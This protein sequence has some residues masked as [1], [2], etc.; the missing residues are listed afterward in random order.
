MIKTIEIEN[1]Q[2]IAKAKIDLDPGINIIIGESDQG[3]SAV[4]KALNWL[5]FNRPQGDAFVR[6][7]GPDKKAPRCSV[8]IDLGE[9]T[10]IKRYRTEGVNAYEIGG[11]KK[12][13]LRTDVPE[14][15][16]NALKVTET[17]IQT[18]FQP[19]FH[20]SQSPG[21]RAKTL[22]SAVG[23]NE[24]DE[25]LG[26]V[27]ALARLAASEEKRLKSEEEQRRAEAAKYAWVDEAESKFKELTSL[28][29]QVN[30][31]AA[32]HDAIG[33]YLEESRRLCEQ[34]E[35]QQLILDAAPHIEHLTK[36]TKQAIETEQWQKELNGIIERIEIYQEDIEKLR[37][38]L[39]AERA[40]NDCMTEAN[41]TITLRGQSQKLNALVCDAKDALA[42]IKEWKRQE[43]TFKKLL[44]E[45]EK[46]N[47]VC[48]MCGK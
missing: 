44:R 35:V 7:I 37:P 5:C 43:A 4:V 18:Q 26:R 24:I 8:S 38:Y 31:K 15:V 11:V 41:K 10:K 2:N 34:I 32:D 23:L 25:V 14:E 39:D 29:D 21:Q 28:W 45:W 42:V 12:K 6:D 16:S 46:N 17:N 22:N 30:R 27:N 19:F 33:K 36:L 13:A 3:K 48:P 20:L 1:F 40:V 47:P 9:G